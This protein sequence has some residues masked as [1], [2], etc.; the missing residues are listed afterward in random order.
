MSEPN[1]DIGMADIVASF[2]MSSSG[3]ELLMSLPSPKPLQNTLEDFFS[4]GDELLMSIPEPIGMNDKMPPTSL[5]INSTNRFKKTT[6]EDRNQLLENSESIR[7]KKST[8]FVVNIFK[9][10][11]IFYP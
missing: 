5:P 9:S 6:E 7:T 11:C 10:K 4:S 8:K 2:E 3:D 1:F